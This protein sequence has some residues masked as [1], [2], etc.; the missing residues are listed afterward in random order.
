MT[1][2]MPT[3][4]RLPITFQRG[5]GAWLYDQDNNAYL[6]ALSGIAVCGLGHSHPAI[7]ATIAEQAATLLH[8][9]NVY[10]IKQQEQLAQKL[11]DISNLDACFFSNSGAEANE[12]AIK[13]ARLYGHTLNIE[14]PTILTMQGSFHGR[15][16]AALSATG[17]DNVKADF[18]PLL[19]GFVNVPYDDIAKIKEI[20]LVNNNIVAIFVEPILGEGGIVI[21]DAN[22]LTSLRKLCD[23]HGWLLM[24]DEIQ[25]GNGRTGQYFGFQHTTI[26]PDILTTAKGLGNGIP[27]GVC[28]ARDTIASLFTAGKHGSTFGGNPLA[29]AV[30]LTVLN[31]LLEDNL[32][33]RAGELG[34]Y[35]LKGLHEALDGCDQVLEIRGKGLMIGIEMHK[36]CP[37][38][39]KQAALEQ[40]LLINVTQQSIIRLL[41]PFIMSNSEADQLIEKLCQL[42]K[43]IR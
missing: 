16:L 24:L 33:T 28:I 30:G 37:N 4:A 27:I 15:T 8:T 1:N 13:L 19:P 3:Y 32:I 2:V 21:P 12:A 26:K 41:P 43:T 14:T 34:D 31:S 17:N 29:C 36:P 40:N 25:T 11:C 9:S 20:A 10:H 42:I 5:A 22:Y 6:D 38:L 7:T 39:T 35:L 23:Q 18:Q